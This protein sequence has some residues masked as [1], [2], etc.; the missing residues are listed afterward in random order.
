MPV[1]GGSI[2]S[3]KDY[4]ENRVDKQ[5]SWY[6]KKSAVHKK[7]FYGLRILQLL[8]TASIPFLTG[9]V[10]TYPNILKLISFF[11]FVLTVLEGILSLTKVY[12]KWIQYRKICELLKK[13]K[14]MYSTNSGVYSTHDTDRFKT[15][16][17]RCESIIS[18]ENLNWTNLTNARKK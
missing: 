4:L 3:E 16:V 14:Y 1:R 8:L 13:E 12:E 9:L 7:C 5:I 17:E 18:D 2:I 11:G 6:D 10:L 15:L